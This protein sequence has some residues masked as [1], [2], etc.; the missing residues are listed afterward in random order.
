[1]YRRE[2]DGTVDT[3]FSDTL[4]DCPKHRV[5]DDKRSDQDRHK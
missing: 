3:D 2:S 1:M 5:K 4:I